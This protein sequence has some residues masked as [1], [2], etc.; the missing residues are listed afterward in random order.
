MAR[1]S[2]AKNGFDDG[3]VADGVLEGDGNFG[4]F[5]NRFG[6]GVA[7]QGVLIADRKCFRNDALA[8]EVASIVDEEASRAV[9]RG[10]EGNFDLHASAGAEEVDA[11]IRD[12][13]RAASKDRLDVYKRQP[14]T[15]IGFP[16]AEKSSTLLVSE[17]GKMRLVM[18]IVPFC[19]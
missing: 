4:A 16:L 12:Q 19:A 15:T 7:L 8:K 18:A 6:E 9:N 17:A 1:V 2:G 10:V 5:Q 14:L 13:L 11:L 3:H